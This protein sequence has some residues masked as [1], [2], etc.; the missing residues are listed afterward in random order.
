MFLHGNPSFPKERVLALG[1]QSPLFPLA[2]R[3]SPSLLTTPPCPS[4]GAGGA[5]R[6]EAWPS[7][8]HRS[9]LPTAPHAASPEPCLPGT[10]LVWRR[11]THHELKPHHRTEA[12]RSRFIWRE[13]GPVG[14]RP[15]C[16]LPG[17]PHSGVV[18]RHQ[19][20]CRASCSGC[21]RPGHS[22]DSPV[23]SSPP[24]EYLLSPKGLCKQAPFWPLRPILRKLRRNYFKSSGCSGVAAGFAV[25][26]SEAL[27][28][29]FPSMDIPECPRQA[30]QAGGLGPWPVPSSLGGFPPNGSGDWLGF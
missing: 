7:P 15:T 24:V 25:C 17:G 23:L 4:S 30:G 27:G 10:R 21:E 14:R 16:V 28:K 2:R 12:G 20:H 22:Q 19:P 18:G 5:R 29:L 13:E 6:Q 9:H 1:T 8:L 3:T 26:H 11:Q